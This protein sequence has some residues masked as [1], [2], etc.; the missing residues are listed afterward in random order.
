MYG[1]TVIIDANRRPNIIV[2]DFNGDSSQDIAVVVRP[3][4][5]MLQEINSEVANWIIF[6]P[7]KI[8]L[9]DLKRGTP[10]VLP[11]PELSYVQQ[12]D[13]LL[14]VIHGTGEAGWRSPKT[15]QAFLL[16]H[17]A[18]ISMQ[19][20]SRK[21]LLAVTEGKEILGAPNYDV[22]N[23]SFEKESRYILWTGAKYVWYAPEAESELGQAQSE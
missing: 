14:A 12:A 18:G 7:G 23:I 8:I 11:K 3:A 2:G 13:V 19:S 16:R 5:G 9:P 15:I 1:K 17:A 22:I 21:E 20:L 4:A 10:L 6:D